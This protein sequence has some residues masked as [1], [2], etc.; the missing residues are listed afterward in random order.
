MLRV[1]QLREAENFS[2]IVR[3]DASR[4]A[5]IVDPLEELCDLVELFVDEDS[6]VP[7]AILETSHAS[8][9]VAGV[10]A[11][12]GEYDVIVHSAGR[13]GGEASGD[14]LS[15]GCS[16]SLGHEQLRALAWPGDSHEGTVLAG[17][18]FVLLGTTFETFK[19]KSLD[20]QILTD[21]LS[22]VSD[23]AKDELILYPR[24]DFHHVL[25]STW[26][27]EKARALE[28]IVEKIPYVRVEEVECLASQGHLLVDIKQHR[29]E[30]G[31]IPQRNRAT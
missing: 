16:I 23:V 4:Q 30:L 19:S 12:Q 11:L 15:A 21:C 6:L 22:N 28:A 2:Y 27:H 20:R 5:I 10:Q 14:R 18:D 8:Q 31:S 26:G 25:F 7:V 9:V 24:E 3:D 29:I 13:S 1:R 17:A